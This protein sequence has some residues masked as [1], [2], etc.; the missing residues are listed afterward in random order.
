MP[1]HR[2][3]GVCCSFERGVVLLPDRLRDGAKITHIPMLEPHTN[4]NVM[5]AVFSQPTYR[6][7]VHNGCVCNEYISLVK[8]HLVYK[9]VNYQAKLWF[10]ITQETRK[11]YCDRL[12]PLTYTQVIE[13][14]R[15]SKRKLYIAALAK[16]SSYGLNDKATVKMFIKPDRYPVDCILEK[17]PRAIQY[18][19]PE[20]NLCF[21]KY[22]KP[23]EHWAY[24][25][26]K[27]GVVS[28]TRVIMKGLNNVERARVLLDKVTYFKR[29]KFYLID[30]SAFDSTISVDHLKSTHSKYYQLMGKGQ[31]RWCC[32]QQL[33]NKARSRHG[34]KYRVKGTRM[35]G[36][37][38]TALGNCIVNCDILYGV[39][40]L[41]G[42][43]KYDWI[44]D[45]DDAVLMVEDGDEIDVGSFS[46]LGFQTKLEVVKDFSKIDFC[47]SRPVCVDDQWMFVR[48]PIR[49]IAHY[50][51]TRL[52]LPVER[53]KEYQ[54][55]IA[56][57]ENSIHGNVPIYAAYVRKFINS[58]YY[59]TDEL[60]QR[61]EGH[62]VNMSIGE[63]SL[64][65]RMS[66]ADAWD[67]PISDQVLFESVITS[68]S[69]SD[70]IENVE[71][72]R[73]TRQRWECGHESSSGGWWNRC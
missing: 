72:L 11:F 47:Q 27:Y 24:E 45:G 61:M 13:Q 29:P 43:T 15:K 28:D 33:D 20:F 52:D 46:Q 63:V 7:K 64:A 23:I 41:S 42:V 2:I 54:A 25:N 68:D 44:L 30:H 40:K 66:F 62:R 22:I 4:H 67:I 1:D 51:I 32:R 5:L 60:R 48:N 38:D 56:V 17:S 34:I 8:R 3:Q 69:E 58:K 65:T 73:R 19:S 57:C 12:L 36:D 21:M 71:S 53:I 6:V 26:L 10:E 31:F 18:R 50:S 59:L 55:G 9:E 70:I 49:A 39:C 16:I 35:S 14:I 37:A